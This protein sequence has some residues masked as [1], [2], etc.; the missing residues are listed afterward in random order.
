M[1]RFKIQRALGV[2]L[3]GLGKTG[4]LE[5]K[6]YGPGE[7]GNSRKKLSDYSIRLKEKQKMRYHYNLKEKQLVNY[8][9]NAKKI[10]TRSWMD[11]LIITLERR[12]TNVVFR[13]QFASSMM[14][15]SQL[16]SHGHILVNG[17]KIDRKN[18]LV[19][20]NDIITLTKKGLSTN[21]YS[22][23]QRRHPLFDIPA[24]YEVK[25]SEGKI[26]DFPIAIDIPFAFESQL[27]I[28]YYSKVK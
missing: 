1:S 27:V 17:K 25:E 9:K 2:E 12:L 19:Q 8:V 24:N 16:I 10:K 5:R 20:K 21:I 26:L 14:A 28:E 4:A 15:S 22:Q 6:P 7:H 18:Y 3:P 13:M 23:A 11:E